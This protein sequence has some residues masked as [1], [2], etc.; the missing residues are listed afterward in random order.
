MVTYSVV[1]PGTSDT[2][3]ASKHNPSPSDDGT[4]VSG[5]TKFI[6]LLSIAEE[7]LDDPAKT[8]VF[9]PFNAFND[10]S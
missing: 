8:G 5:T 3:S 2:D 6:S 10:V 4:V 9:L 1:S 7:R